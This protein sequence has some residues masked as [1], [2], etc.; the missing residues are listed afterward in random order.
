MG[1]IVRTAGVGKS[2]EEL[3]WDLRFLLNNWENIKGAADQ[4]PAPFLIHQ[5]SNVI[6][7]ALRDTYVAT[8]VKS[9][10]IAT[11][12]TSARANIFNWYAQTS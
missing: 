10:L 4:N 7:R 9:L 3:E 8:L 11:R 2:A 1:L 6:V 5:E 12:F